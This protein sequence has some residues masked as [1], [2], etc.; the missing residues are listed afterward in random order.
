ME[1]SKVGKQIRAYRK[2]KKLTISDVENKAGLSEGNLSRIERG[3]QWVSEEKLNSIAEALGVKV[4]DLF[5]EKH[6]SEAYI[7]MRDDLV[8]SV[9]IVREEVKKNPA[10][11]LTNVIE[12]PVL[13]VSGSMGSGYHLQDRE[14]VVE[15]M[16]VSA[17]W[18]RR[19][20]NISTPQNLALI[21]A[22]GDSMECTFNDGDLLLVDRGVND[23]RID[24]VY[25]LSLND[26]LYIKRLQRRPDGGVLMIS[27][28]KKYEPY[29]IQNGDRDKFRVLGRVLLA[30]NS[31]KL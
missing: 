5:T 9:E 2:A 13:D 23:I 31:R 24:A 17:P 14:E 19:N 20:V 16:I 27:D 12:I 22:Y 3:I 15:R 1:N 11:W 4:A 18:L 8:A 25:V 28:N 30:W 29:L 7:R 21:S 26:E 10:N 6:E